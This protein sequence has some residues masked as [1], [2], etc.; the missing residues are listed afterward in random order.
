MLYS[1]LILFHNTCTSRY[2]ISQHLYKQV[3]YFTTP[4]QAGK[5]FHYTCTGRYIISQHL[6]EQVGYIISRHLFGQVYSPVQAGIFPSHVLLLLQ[7]NVFVSEPSLKIYPG[8]H[9]YDTLRPT[10]FVGGNTCMVCL[11]IGIGP[12]LSS[13]K[14]STRCQ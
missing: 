8:S 2:I 6:Y 13:T 4:V 10:S 12:H 3:Y 9:A 5:L 7:V 1:W 11:N 14:C